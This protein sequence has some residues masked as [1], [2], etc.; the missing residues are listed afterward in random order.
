[1]QVGELC[2]WDVVGVC[3]RKVCRKKSLMCS[4]F[5]GGSGVGPGVLAA[6]HL[7]HHFG[8][9]PTDPWDAAAGHDRAPE[10]DCG[11]QIPRPYWATTPR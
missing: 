1:M 9:V 4:E 8:W 11:P 3:W 5:G 7:L 2:G 6:L 10:I